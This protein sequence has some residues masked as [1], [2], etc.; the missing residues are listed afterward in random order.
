MDYMYLILYYISDLSTQKIF[1]LSIAIPVLILF[2]NSNNLQNIAYNIIDTHN[3]YNDELYTYIE[4]ELEIVKNICINNVVNLGID[5]Y[6]LK[7]Y[8]LSLTCTL[9]IVKDEIIKMIDINGFHDMNQVTL[10]KYISDKN[11][12]ILSISRLEIMKY[13]HLYPTLIGTDEKRFT[14]D[15]SLVFVKNIINKAIT[16]HKQENIEIIE[17]SNKNNILK[18]IMNWIKSCIKK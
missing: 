6:E 14:K 10:D 17:L 7:S 11:D 15:N 5:D 8:M 9:K 4:G 2:V 18:H 1:L 13:N 16:L 12:M 3:K